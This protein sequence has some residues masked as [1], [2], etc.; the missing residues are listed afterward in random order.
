MFLKNILC[1]P[2]H[3]NEAVVGRMHFKILLHL[4]GKNIENKEKL[5]FF[6]YHKIE[7]LH[8]IYTW[9]ASFWN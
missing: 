6:F 5:S 8:S 3:Q 1:D 7:M 9:A 2:S 4:Y